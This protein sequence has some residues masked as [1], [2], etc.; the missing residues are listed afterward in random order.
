MNRAPDPCYGTNVHDAGDLPSL[1]AML[2]GPAAAVR[3][4][5]G[6][7]GVLGLGLWLPARAAWS[8]ASSPAAAAEVKARLRDGGL[9]VDTVNAFP[10]GGFHDA[11]VKEAAYRPDW[12]EPE[13]LEYTK[14]AARAATRL[15]EPGATC[16]ISTVPG[17]WKG[18]ADGPAEGRTL[19]R[20]LAAAAESLAGLLD[21]TGVRIV[22]APEP[23]PGCTLETV[24]ETVDFWR[25]DLAHE[26][27]SRADRLLPHL[28]LCLD[29]CHAAVVGEDPAEAI[30]RLRRAGV[31][32]AK[33]QV[34]A[35]LEVDPADPAEVAALRAFDEPRWLHQVGAL[36][37]FGVLHR[38]MDLP[39]V[40]AAI[41]A[42]SRR[43][44]WRVHF[45]APLHMA[46]VAGVRTTRDLVAPA[47]A[48]ALEEGTPPVLEVETYTWSAV[49][50]FSGS[51]GELASNIAAEI[52]F[53]R[54]AASS[55]T[56][57]G[58][59]MEECTPA[60]APAPRRAAP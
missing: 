12:S 5:L 55:R 3:A 27:G 22:L 56:P 31:P 38:A 6:G 8:I 57:P 34:S 21:A 2:G 37:R 20:G 17:A 49:P 7:G 11:R 32:V 46:V 30:R 18:R 48:A 44:P 59:M 1:L 29:L 45:H 54:E 9:R 35:A 43:R 24:R 53:A 13:R 42:W 51:P 52:R 15:V 41:P 10:A 58:P 39:E 4:A 40:L 14:A 50:G 25:R 47:L 23:E 33:V 19:A 36:D 16:V 28:G 60:A 26:I